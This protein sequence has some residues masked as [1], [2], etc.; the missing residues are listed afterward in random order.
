MSTLTREVS[1][2]HGD[3]T[4][5]KRKFNKLY[6][7]MR[8]HGPHFFFLVHVHRVSEDAR[9]E[10]I[11]FIRRYR[12]GLNTQHISLRFHRTSPPVCIRGKPP[13]KS[14]PSK[15]YIRLVLFRATLVA[16]DVLR[17]VFLDSLLDA[18]PLFTTV[19]VYWNKSSSFEFFHATSFTQLKSMF[20]SS[21]LVGPGSLVG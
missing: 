3:P 20:G 10:K 2:L 21:E 12:T 8:E 4:T 14:N 5:A 16:G 7:V 19:T 13:S 6:T 17:C 9:C 1:H 11:I 18:F 15:R